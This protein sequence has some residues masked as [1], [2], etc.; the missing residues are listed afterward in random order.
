[1]NQMWQVALKYVFTVFVVKPVLAFTSIEQHP[2]F[3]GQCSVI[4]NADFNNK[5]TC[6]KQPS[7]FKG[8]FTVS[9]DSLLKKLRLMIFMNKETTGARG[10]PQNIKLDQQ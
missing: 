3:S 6:I 9:C 8:H 4:P 2:A 7:A 5:L 1:M 10:R